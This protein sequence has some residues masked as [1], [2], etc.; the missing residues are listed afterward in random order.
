MEGPI[1]ENSYIVGPFDQFSVNIWTGIPISFTLPVTSEG[2]LIIPTVGEVSAADKTLKI[3]KELAIKEIRRKYLSGD[4]TVTLLSPRKVTVIISGNVKFPGVYTLN[5]SDRVNTLIEMANEET[6]TRKFREK[7]RTEQDLALSTSL[8]PS[9]RHIALRRRTTGIYRVDLPMYNATKREQ[10]NP[11]L[12]GGDEIYVPSAEK[13]KSVIAI[14]GGVKA[15]GRFEYVEGDS[16][17][18]LLKMALGFSQRAIPD[19]VELLR[20]DETLSKLQS[21]IFNGNAILKK[22]APDLPLKSGDR[23]IV[24]ETP[25]FTEDFRVQ[26]EGEVLFPGVYPITKNSTRISRVI[27]MAGGFTPNASLGSAL[28]IRRS[29]TPEEAVLERFMALRGVNNPEDTSYN[30]LE[31]ELRLHQEIVSI[32]LEKLF[33]GKETSQDVILQSDDRIVVPSTEN[34]V[35]VFG[36]TMAPG[37]VTFI[38]G[39]PVEYYIDRAGGYT[40]L[41]RKGDVMVVKKRTKQWVDPSET[42]V[43]SGDYIWIPRQ[44]YRPFSYYMSYIS[45]V[46]SILSVAITLIILTTK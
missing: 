22:T 32:N 46:A 40:D 33:S 11:M 31:S 1:D 41:A 39:K 36:Q 26:V 12:Q 21:T 14:Y 15:P 19:S 6:E 16:L 35:Y 13:S 3:V 27:E 30:S 28:L 34:A 23:I 43:E 42:T 8:E 9:R 7:E 17:S 2:T 18:S 45:Q 10:L 4:V 44:L 24:K 25:D 29:L 38:P 20:F 5:A 37:W